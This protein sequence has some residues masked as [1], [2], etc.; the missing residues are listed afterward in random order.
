MKLRSDIDSTKID[1]EDNI[2]YF[3]WIHHI[4]KYINEDKSDQVN[5]LN[6]KL[7]NF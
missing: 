4:I 5:G 7:L 2:L 3:G 6:S 1:W